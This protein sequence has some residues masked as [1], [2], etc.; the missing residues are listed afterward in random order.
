MKLLLDECLPRKFKHPL[1]GH[2]CQHSFYGWDLTVKLRKHEL[3]VILSGRQGRE[4]SRADWQECGVP[5][6]QAGPH[7]SHALCGKVARQECQTPT[8]PDCHSER[9]EESQPAI[10]NGRH[11]VRNGLAMKV[12]PQQRNIILSQAADEFIAQVIRVRGHRVAVAL[13]VG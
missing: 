6:N 13:L 9:S 12:R 11:Y 8:Q 7:P 4:G 10:T 3:D 2:E 5:T 1:P